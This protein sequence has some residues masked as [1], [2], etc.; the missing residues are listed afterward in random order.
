MP[1]IAADTDVLIRSD[2]HVHGHENASWQG[3][4]EGRDQNDRSPSQGAKTAEQL[5]EGK[6]G[7]WGVFSLITCSQNQPAFVVKRLLGQKESYFDLALPNFKALEQ[8][9]P[10]VKPLCLQ[11]FVSGWPASLH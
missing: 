5:P 1:W 4:R 9:I 3:I 11:F 8:C 7:A 2:T 10:A 6:R